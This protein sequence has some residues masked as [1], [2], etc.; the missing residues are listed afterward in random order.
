MKRMLA[1][2]LQVKG[3]G[4][5]IGTA[6]IPLWVAYSAGSE[7]T[8]VPVLSGSG[9]PRGELTIRVTFT[10]DPKAAAAQARTLL[11]VHGRAMLTL[12]KACISAGFAC[13]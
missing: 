10:P 3:S 11:C 1:R 7:F 2:W 6:R 8:S 13:A 12:C 4:D 9:K 5:L